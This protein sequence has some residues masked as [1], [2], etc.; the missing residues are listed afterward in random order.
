MSGRTLLL[1][2]LALAALW[3]RAETPRSLASRML[4]A[5]E[6][7]RP[8]AKAMR[9]A[10]DPA[11]G[12][13][14]WPFDVARIERLLEK[15]MDRSEDGSYLLRNESVAPEGGGLRERADAAMA[16][17]N[18]I[19]SEWAVMMLDVKYPRCDAE[20]VRALAGYRVDMDRGFW[21]SHAIST[22]T[23]MI[24]GGAAKMD[25]WIAG[26]KLSDR[27]Y[28]LLTNEL[29][30]E[31]CPRDYQFVMWDGR[32]DWPIAGFCAFPDAFRAHTALTVLDS[33]V[34]A[35]NLAA[36]LHAREAN[37]GAFMADYVESLL[38]RA[39]SGGCEA[40]FYNLGVLMEERG[41]AEQAAAFF[42]R[43]AHA[44]GK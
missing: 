4:D 13:T 35:N 22:K 24:G 37:R 15:R 10:D 40:A 30:D 42:S 6:G 21:S 23:G 44:T 1:M 33:P 7:F 31:T 8:P 38:R 27:I 41:D 19:F 14:A 26:W 29:R 39:A 20:T 34:A 43:D 28:L 36:L 17:V 3:G 12:K 5:R 16:Y 32:K 9:I 25:G 11:L 2:T 18:R